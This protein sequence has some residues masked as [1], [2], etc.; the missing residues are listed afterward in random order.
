M[1]KFATIALALTAI[2][3]QANT[4]KQAVIRIPPN[5]IP[6]AYVCDGVD[7]DHKKVKSITH[8]A[9][10]SVTIKHSRKKNGRKMRTSNCTKEFAKVYG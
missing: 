4:P 9:D 8:K 6:T 2:T 1:K 10:G 7:I 5:A 3:A